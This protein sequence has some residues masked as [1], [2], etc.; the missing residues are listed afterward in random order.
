MSLVPNV[1][2]LQPWQGN[3]PFLLELLEECEEELLASL[4]PEEVDA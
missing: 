2:C 1:G 4:A 3:W